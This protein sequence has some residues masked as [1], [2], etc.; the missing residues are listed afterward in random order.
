MKRFALL[1]LML[2]V[3]APAFAQTVVQPETPLADWRSRLTLAAGAQYAVDS[4]GGAT[5]PT[6]I[7]QNKWELGL[8]SAYNLT[9]DVDFVSGAFYRTDNTLRSYFGVNF[10]LWDF[11][12][13]S[14]A[15]QIGARVDYSLDTTNDHSDPPAVDRNA[16]EAGVVAAA[17]LRGRLS[18]VASSFYRTD[19]SFRSTI[20]VRVNIVEP[21]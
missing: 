5:D 3:A 20:G 11:T 15:G 21:R 13:S 18:A 19:N 10:A 6:V 12:V 17:R 9:T 14:L 2:L 16:W 1:F 4:R 7:T 8:V